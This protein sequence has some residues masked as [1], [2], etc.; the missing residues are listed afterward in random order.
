MKQ[1]LPGDIIELDLQKGFTYLQIINLHSSYPEIIR[2]FEG[3]YPNRPENLNFLK[4]S[5][6]KIL[7]MVPL[8][9]LIQSGVVIGRKVGTIKIPKEFEPFPTFHMPIYDKKGGVIYSWFWAGE[10]IWYD[11]SARITDEQNYLKREV[12]SANMLLERIG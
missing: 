6:S 11:D 7:G 2:H 5:K 10:G 8:T 1:F 12:L 3:I 4:E 9:N